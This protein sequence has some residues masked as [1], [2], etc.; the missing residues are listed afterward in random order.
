[1]VLKPVGILADQLPKPMLHSSQQFTSI[2]RAYTFIVPVTPDDTLIVYIAKEASSPPVRD[3]PTMRFPPTHRPHNKA[4]YYQF[5]TSNQLSQI[6]QHLHQKLPG[7]QNDYYHYHIIVGFYSYNPNTQFVPTFYELSVLQ[8]LIEPFDST[9]V[10]NL[11]FHTNV[12]I[13]QII[14]NGATKL[15]HTSTIVEGK[16]SDRR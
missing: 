8:Y 4:S 14:F 11:L 9:N 7:F 15:L 1:M 5:I 2:I 16:N 6:I 12:H 13:S 3:P 10:T